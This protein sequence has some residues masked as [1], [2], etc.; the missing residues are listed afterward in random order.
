MSN[1]AKTQKRIAEIY[2]KDGEYTLAMKQY[3]QAADNYSVEPNN[4]SNM[5][6]CLL[7]VV[8]IGLFVAAPDYAEMIKVRPSLARFWKLLLTSTC[9]VS[10]QPRVPR[11]YTSSRFCCILLT[12]TSSGL[13]RPCSATSTMIPLSYKLGSKSSRRPSSPASRNK[14]SRYS[15]TSGTMFPIKLQIQR[16]HPIRQMEDYCTEQGQGSDSRTRS[17]SCSI[18]DCQG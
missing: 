14:T 15:L 6:T 17:S 11:N 16:D 10:L 1:V 2:E 18:Q 3:K 9:K 12:T 7:K 8:D 5:N 4:N 13:P